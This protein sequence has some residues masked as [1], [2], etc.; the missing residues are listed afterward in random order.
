M[1]IEKIIDVYLLFHNICTNEEKEIFFQKLAQ[2]IY[3][4][5]DL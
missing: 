5:Y 3:D 4:Y 2:L 1:N